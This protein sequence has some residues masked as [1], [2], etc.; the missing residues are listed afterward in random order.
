MILTF[1]DTQGTGSARSYSDWKDLLLWQ[2]YHRTTSALSGIKEFVAVAEKARIEIQQRLLKNLDGRLDPAEIVA[3]FENLP[4]SYFETMSED[5]IREHIAIVHSFLKYQI[6]HDDA[7]LQPSVHWRNFPE[8]GHSEV[9][10]VTW[11]RDRIFRRASPA[12]SPPAA[13]RFWKA[14]I[15]TRVDDIAIET[16]YVAHR[17]ARSRHRPAGTRAAFEKILFQAMGADQFDFNTVFAKRAKPRPSVYDAS[18][19]PTPGLGRSARPRAIIPCSTSRPPII[20]ACSTASPEPSPT[21]ASTSSPPR[22]TTEKGGP[23]SNTFYLCGAD[24]K[25]N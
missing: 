1:A 23:R 16:Y 5:L 12:L 19:F 3:H 18:E 2:L 13:S 21:R 11:D 20:P 6:M 17:P 8:Q 10:V 7:S 9:T 22:V 24:G 4:P 14:D 15:Y 25:K